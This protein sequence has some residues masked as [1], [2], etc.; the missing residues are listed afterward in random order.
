MPLPPAKELITEAEAGAKGV[1]SLWLRVMKVLETQ[2]KQTKL[3][4]AQA[5]QIEALRDAVR[6]LQAREDLLLAKVETAA[7]QATSDISRRVGFLE[8]RASRE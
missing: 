6:V 5:T 7:A 3:I 8:G 1:F 4:E 2:D